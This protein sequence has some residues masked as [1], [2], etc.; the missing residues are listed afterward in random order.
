V[1]FPFLPQRK[2]GRSHGGKPAPS[3][4]RHPGLWVP[5]IASTG[6]GSIINMSSISWMIPSTGQPAYIA[7]KA[8]IVGLTRTMAHELGSKNI[9]VN[10]VLPGSIR[11]ERQRRLWLTPEYE[12]GSWPAGRSNEACC[13]KT[14]RVWSYSWRPTTALRYG[15]VYF[16]YVRATWSQD[17][18]AS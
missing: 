11:T 9:R 2:M 3:I 7:A 12:A 8:A 16:C 6:G 14:S 1:I 17:L 5:K 18:A 4:F 15:S 10:S 13:R